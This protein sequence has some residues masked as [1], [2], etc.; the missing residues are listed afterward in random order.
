L[1]NLVNKGFKLELDCYTTA[2]G[3]RHFVPEDA[4]ALVIKAS[5]GGF[6]IR[7]TTGKLSGRAQHEH[8]RAR[9]LFQL[10]PRLSEYLGRKFTREQDLYLA[11]AGRIQGDRHVLPEYLGLDEQGQG[12]PWTPSELIERGRALAL[13]SGCAQPTPAQCIALGLFAAARLN[14]FDPNQLTMV[15]V[16]SIVRQGLFELDPESQKPTPSVVRRVADRLDEA[17]AAHLNDD[18]KEFEEWFLD[19]LDNIV[20]RIAKRKRPDGPIPRDIVREAVL[21][22]V[23]KAFVQVGE[24]AHQQMVAFREAL[25][26]PLERKER[27]IFDSLYVGRRYLGGLP[28][29]LLRDRFD[30]LREA[31]L[32]VMNDP[33]NRRHQGALLRLLDFYG[34]MATTKREAD[35]RYKK[36]R[37][38]RNYQGRSAQVMV[39][40]PE[41]TAGSAGEPDL[42]Q[43][44]AGELREGRHAT[45]DCST[46]QHWIARVAVEEPPEPGVVILEDICT[47][48]GRRELVPVPEEHLKEIGERL[49]T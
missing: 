39:I 9:L 41:L 2:D 3:S 31:M 10:G 25:P 46:L 45:C 15:E 29:L 26:E 38:H 23:F 33:A 35:R 17:L 40:K 49:T 1:K 12:Q 32:A 42:F 47:E 36:H 14:P 19:N 22:L 24:S 30:F 18:T 13:D 37:H 48:C 4:R 44:I 27:M 20:H 6:A 8:Q 11:K 43:E 16:R 5:L 34:K 21:E 28:L 7:Q